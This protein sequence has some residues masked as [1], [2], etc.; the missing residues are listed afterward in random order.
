MNKSINIVKTG[1]ENRFINTF[2]MFQSLSGN[3]SFYACF[4]SGEKIF[5]VKVFLRR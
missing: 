4:I 2:V 5:A 3:L 1:E